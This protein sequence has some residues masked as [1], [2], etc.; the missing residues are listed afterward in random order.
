MANVPPADANVPPANVPPDIPARAP[1]NVP[2]R[3]MDDPSSDEEEPIEDPVEAALRFKEVSYR[4][5]LQRIGVQD[6]GT[7]DYLYNTQGQR[8]IDDLEALD[9]DGIKDLVHTTNK[10]P[11]GARAQRGVARNHVITAVSFKK[12]KAFREWIKWQR[13]TERNVDA[14]FFR[15]T[16]M[17]FH[18]MR[19][20]YEARQDKATSPEIQ[21][22]EPLTTIGHKAWIP[23]WRQFQNYCLTIRGTLN[24]PIVYVYREIEA[25][26]GDLFE[27]FKYQSS[28]EA[29]CANCLL[30]GMYFNEDNAIVWN[31]IESLTCDGNAFPFIKMYSKTRNGRAAILALKAQCEGASSTENRKQAAYKIISTQ[32]YD[33]K[34]RFTWDNY[35]EKLQYAFAELEE[36][37]DPQSESHKIHILTSMCTSDKMK[38]GTELIL[39]DSY[40]FDTFIKASESLKSHYERN[41]SSDKYQDRRNVASTDTS[42]TD[43]HKVL[44]ASYS[45]EE[46]A[47]LPQAVKDRVLKRNRDRKNKAKDADDSPSPEDSNTTSDSKK[48]KYK[49]RRIKKLESQ[50]KI[51]KAG[52]IPSNDTNDGNSSDQDEDSD[53][54][55]VTKPASKRNKT[56]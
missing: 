49:K 18:M 24:I 21:K 5:A 46:W 41:V 36:C 45:R 35:V 16:H 51:A 29:L 47:K 9:L 1:P 54:T 12:L 37:G 28:D 6:V 27:E 33:G 34:G 56:S 4:I 17:E 7:L 23:F 11:S 26:A 8:T 43:K 40:R 30:S 19:I 22:P 39:S 32:T 55:P 42:D 2:I 15:Q 14:N 10:T 3:Y 25:P 38:L 50:L 31:L 13:A 53:A 44:K 20:D 48:I 52:T